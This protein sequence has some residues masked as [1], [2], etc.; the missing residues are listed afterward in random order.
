M[1]MTM[2]HWKKYLWKEWIRQC[3]VIS[4]STGL[5][6]V[7]P[8][9]GFHRNHVPSGIAVFYPKSADITL[10]TSQNTFNRETSYN[11]KPWNNSSSTNIL[12]SDTRTIPSRN[13]RHR[14]KS[15]TLLHADTPD[16]LTS[17]ASSTPSFPSSMLTYSLP[18]YKVWYDLS[19][20]TPKWSLVAQS[21][22]SQLP[23]ISSKNLYKLTGKQ[24]PVTST[25]ANIIT[26]VVSVCGRGYGTLCSSDRNMKVF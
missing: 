17:V 15:S 14:S 5:I 3:A 18:F 20:L 13:L 9:S 10:E 22:L 26:L 2:V 12:S 21:S 4:N 8:S 6:F 1:Y 11:M 25:E 16:G 24:F 23:I 7:K 19:H